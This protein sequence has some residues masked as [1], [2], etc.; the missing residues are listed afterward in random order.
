MFVLRLVTV[1][2]LQGFEPASLA[3]KPSNA[4]A[5][6]AQFQNQRGSIVTGDNVTIAES[7]P[8]S[9]IYKYQRYY[10]H[11]PEY[12]PVTGYD[13]LYS[14]SGIEYYENSV[15]N[16]SDSSLTVRNLIDLLTGKQRKGA[17]VTVTVNSRAQNAAWTAL[18]SMTNGK[19]RAVAALDPQT[20]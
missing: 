12:A 9:D 14:Q 3:S 2:S 6:E 17:S 16:G 10:P 7:R 4:R 15:L 13:T 19:P 11:G 8:S 1:P 18:E 20:G 5:F